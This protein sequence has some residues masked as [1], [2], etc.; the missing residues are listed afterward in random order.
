[1]EEAS[2]QLAD[3]LTAKK[4]AVES[5]LKAAV[6][7]GGDRAL[8]DTLRCRLREVDKEI[9]RS[10]GEIRT[11]LRAIALERK[12][13]VE[14]ARAE[15]QAEEARAKELKLLLDLRTKEAEIAKTK[16]KEAALAAKTAL[17]SAKKEKHDAALLRAKAEEEDRALRLGFA[18]FLARQLS[19]YFQHND[20][21]E[22]RKSRCRKLAVAQAKSKAGMQQIEV[23]RLWSATTAGLQQLQGQSQVIQGLRLRAKSEI[24]YASSDFCW[25]MFGPPKPKGKENRWDARYEPRYAFHKLV[26]RTMPGYFH[27][28]GS[29]YGIDFLLAQHCNILDLAYVS[30]NWR[31]TWLTNVKLYRC[32]L[33]AWP[34]DP[35]WRQNI[36]GAVS[37]GAVASGGTTSSG[38]ATSSGASTASGGAIASGGAAGGAK[39]S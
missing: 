24:L 15:S 29:R 22:E 7:A 13:K 16:T 38:G 19:A 5:A 26:D 4:L 35:A 20:K 1:M 23:P 2:K 11:N 34:P 18:A 31:Y 10:G 25:E 17:E 39:S 30:A 3:S 14:I 27:V 33:V 12:R 8:E 9:N 32:G 36:G 28:L 37:G 6:S 21:G